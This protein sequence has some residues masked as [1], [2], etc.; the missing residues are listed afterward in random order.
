[1]KQK[2]LLVGGGGF[3]GHNLA[4]FLKNKKYDVFAIDNFNINNLGFIKKHLKDKKKKELY[5]SFINE[6]IKLLKKYK[7]PIKK[8]DA[9]NKQSL[10]KIVKFY[11]P[12]VLIHLAA[13]SHDGRSNQNPELAYQNSF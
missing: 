10:I 6:R 11:K 7:V 1:M 13:V 3:I 5:R 2:I 4:I 9:T 12:D 8:I